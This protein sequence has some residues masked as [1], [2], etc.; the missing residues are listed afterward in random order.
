[1]KPWKFGA[2]GA[3]LLVVTLAFVIITD[4]VSVNENEQ[5]LQ[6]A[7]GRVKNPHM[8]TGLNLLAFSRAV[9][10]PLTDQTYG[11][12]EFRAM[13]KDS[14]LVTGTFTWVWA[15]NRQEI[16]ALYAA[17]GNAASAQM[18]IEQG[19][20][21]GLQ[22]AIAKFRSDELYSQ[23]ELVDTELHAQIDRVQRGRAVT[24]R[25]FVRNALPP[26]Q[27]LAARVAV[28][29]K[30]LALQAARRQLAVD[31]AQAQGKVIQASATAEA[32]RLE[33]QSYSQNPR[34]MDLEIAKATAGGIAKLCAGTNVTT[35]I[36]GASVMDSWKRP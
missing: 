8:G 11:P 6:V 23:P 7:Y 35:C 3:L 27:I 30:G 21:T 25:A 20:L 17:K 15:H 18:E 12:V 5:C 36:V 10:F 13:A 16:E 33:A 32:K 14:I 31:S 26:Q 9:C 29:E 1:M 22:N 34:L 19:A 24:K 2:L 28:Q 4:W